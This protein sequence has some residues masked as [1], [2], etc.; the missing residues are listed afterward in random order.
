[1]LPRLIHITGLLLVLLAPIQ[2]LAAS[3]LFARGYTV[4]P[5]PQK[6]RLGARDFEFTQAWRLE[7]G[8]GIQSDDISV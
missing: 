2:V 1:M 8:A 5:S 3:P 6:V 4:L 7:S